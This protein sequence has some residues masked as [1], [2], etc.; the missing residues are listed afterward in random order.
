MEVLQLLIIESTLIQQQ[1]VLRSQSWISE[2][3][4]SS[5]RQAFLSLQEKHISLK[6]S[7]ETLLVTQQ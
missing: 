7:R 6:F 3:H 5:I 1:T 2:S 4:S